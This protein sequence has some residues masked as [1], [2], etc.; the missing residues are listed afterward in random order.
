MK[1]IWFSF[2]LPESIRSKLDIIA[3]K[4]SETIPFSP[5]RYDD[6]HMTCI[7]LGK[8]PKSQ[9]IAQIESIIKSHNLKG[10]MRFIGLE[11]FPPTKNNL[12]IARFDAAK[13]V[14]K[15]IEQI[16]QDIKDI[17]KYDIDMEIIPHITLGKI[18]LSKTELID[19][20][21]KGLD[22]SD[23]DLS[24]LNFII[25]SEKPLYLCGF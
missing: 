4:I 23:L 21:S 8:Q 22:K 3:I 10:M 9:D 13:E 14:L 18:N 6:I 11:F 19:L 2:T 17:M 1:N 5:M 15:I 7:F 24:D 12:I 25:D 16:K 20:I